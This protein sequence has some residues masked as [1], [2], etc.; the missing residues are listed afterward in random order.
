[1]IKS[2]GLSAIL[3][4]FIIELKEILMP[5]KLKMFYII[6]SLGIFSALWN[7]AVIVPGFKKGD[8]SHPD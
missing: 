7:V 1:M 6:L 2:P 8:N 4:E 5:I 3:N